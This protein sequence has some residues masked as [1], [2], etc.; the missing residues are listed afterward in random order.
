V[1]ECVV[2]VYK[3][4]RERAR[5]RGWGGDQGAFGGRWGGWGYV[6]VACVLLG[7]R[8]ERERER[9]QWEDEDI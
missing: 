4:A 6:M 2:S 8:R 3:R 7:F 1:V 5:E 9:P